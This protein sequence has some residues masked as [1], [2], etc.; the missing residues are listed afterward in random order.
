MIQTG[1]ETMIDSIK[2]NPFK[3]KKHS[4]NDEK[5]DS[6]PKQGTSNKK[7]FTGIMDGMMK[8]KRKNSGDRNDKV[9][10]K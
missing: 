6:T 10:K 2:T 5:K 1:G 7:G 8:R 9:D 3:N 4:G